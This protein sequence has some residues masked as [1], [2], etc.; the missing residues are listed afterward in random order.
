MISISRG[1]LILDHVCRLFK[2][3][4]WPILKFRFPNRSFLF[5]F[6]PSFFSFA[7]LGQENATVLGAKT[8]SRLQLH[9]HRQGGDN[10]TGPVLLGVSKMCQAF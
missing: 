4:W 2:A 3:G 8:T 6:P 5:E 10:Q 9:L 7:S 1:I